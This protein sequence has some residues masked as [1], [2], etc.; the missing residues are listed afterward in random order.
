M[1]LSAA[2]GSRLTEPPFDFNN[3]GQFDEG[4]TDYSEMTE[5]TITGLCPS[6]NC[7]AP[8]GILS[9]GVAQAPTIINC[10]TELECKYQ[11]LSSGDINRVGENPGGSS[12]GRQSWMEQKGN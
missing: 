11:S 1:E 6:G 10:G 2:D 5:T 8:S 12:L 7:P 4:D 9:E 3:D